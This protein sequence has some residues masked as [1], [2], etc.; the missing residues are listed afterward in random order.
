METENLNSILPLITAVGS[1]ITPILVLIL[2]GLGWVIANRYNKAREIEEKLRDDRVKIYNDILEP[3]IL[4]FTKDDGLP[5][6]KDFRGK[7]HAE[8]A[9]E[10]MLSLAYKQ[11]LF[12][13]SL[14]G[15]DDVVQ[16]LNNLMQFFYSGILSQLQDNPDS[17]LKERMT[18]ELMRLLGKLLLEIRKSVGNESSKLHYFEML[19]FLITDVRK[20]QSNGK[21]K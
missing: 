8:I 7:N 11:T 17:S 10:K 21:Y 3:F 1:I 16:A 15:S 13:L 12:K 4:L 9:G 2:S 5:K 14:I 18:K 19:E 20:Y 6:T